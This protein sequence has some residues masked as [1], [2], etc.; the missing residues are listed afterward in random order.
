ME[1]VEGDLGVGKVRLDARDE[2][3]PMS[4]EASVMFSRLPPC[5]SRNAAK[6]STL[7]NFFSLMSRLW[8]GRCFWR[9]PGLL[10]NSDAI[11]PPIPI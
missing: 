11:R 7:L 2:R 5:A 6:P 1:L 10:A 9:F 8:P 3:R 4:I